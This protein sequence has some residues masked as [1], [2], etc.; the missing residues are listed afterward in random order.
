MVRLCATAA[1]HRRRGASRLESNTSRAT[2]C[3]ARVLRLG[4][5]QR[6]GT[7]LGDEGSR[8][9]HARYDPPGAAGAVRTGAHAA[10]A[11]AAGDSGSWSL[12]QGVGP[13]RLPFRATARGACCRPMKSALHVPSSLNDCRPTLGQWGQSAAWAVERNLQIADQLVPAHRFN[14]RQFGVRGRRVEKAT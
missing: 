6:A 12:A 10:A 4:G 7:Q 14:A 5:P 1:H 11:A 3:P 9:A 13:P 2:S 8:C